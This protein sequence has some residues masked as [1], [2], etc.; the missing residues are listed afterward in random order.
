MGFV[1]KPSDNDSLI[2][3]KEKSDVL[4]MKFLSKKHFD[5]SY[6][7]TTIYQFNKDKNNI[8][9]SIS[10][11]IDTLKNMKLSKIRCIYDNEKSNN[12]SFILP[13]RELYLELFEFK[14]PNEKEIIDFVNRFAKAHP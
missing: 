8:D 13:A 4:L 12:Y 1:I 11:T 14:L 10:K 3:K 2:E 9:Y 7:D 6:P 5:E